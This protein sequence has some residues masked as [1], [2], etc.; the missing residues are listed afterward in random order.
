MPPSASGGSNAD[1]LSDDLIERVATDGL[2][3]PGPEAALT[4]WHMGGAVGEVAP[5]GTAYAWRDAPF[6]VS[7]DAGWRDPADDETHLAWAES[8]SSV[9]SLLNRESS[10]LDGLSTSS[11]A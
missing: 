4:V 7:I 6:L 2:A 3:R 11:A 9:P 8:T 10:P 1:E 5:D